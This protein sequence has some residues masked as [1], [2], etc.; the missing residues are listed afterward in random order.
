MTL[1]LTLSL[2]PSGVGKEKGAMST[3]PVST[4]PLTER[5]QALLRKVKQLES[6]LVGLSLAQQRR[7]Q[8]GQAALN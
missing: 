5:E 1:T 8:Q 7:V 2:H 3:A 4:A 6:E